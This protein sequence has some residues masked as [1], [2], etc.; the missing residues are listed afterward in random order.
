MIVHVYTWFTHGGVEAN[1]E[2]DGRVFYSTYEGAIDAKGRVSIPAP[3]RAALGGNSRVFI[4][5]AP[6]GSGA[7]EGGGEAL[8]DLYAETLAELPLQSPVREAFVTSVIAGSADLKIDD[9]GRIR[10]PDEFCEAAG[11]TGRIRFTG[12]IESFKIWD[13]ARFDAHRQKQ[14]GVAQQPD[15]LDAFH[16]AYRDVRKRRASAA[17]GEAG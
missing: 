15:T 2:Q 9:T 8:M 14:A 11:I 5:I 7:L 16:A 4:W 3:F 6:D 12:A 17:R 10:L 1:P 13:P